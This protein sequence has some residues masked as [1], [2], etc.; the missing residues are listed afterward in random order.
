ME[1]SSPLS[2]G[3]RERDPGNEVEIVPTH[4]KLTATIFGVGIPS[5]FITHLFRISRMPTVMYAYSLLHT[6]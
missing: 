6:V 3:K 5:P 2:G 4:S 1:N